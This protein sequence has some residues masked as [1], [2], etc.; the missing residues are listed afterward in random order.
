MSKLKLVNSRNF[1]LKLGLEFQ[2]TNHVQPNVG[3][4]YHLRV[5]SRET[6]VYVVHIFAIAIFAT[7]FMH[8]QVRTP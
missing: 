3:D 2:Q 8:V 5:L 1:C 7:F 6:F 4:L